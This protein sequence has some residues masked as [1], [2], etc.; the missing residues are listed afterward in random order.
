[1]LNIYEL[2]SFKQLIEEPARLSLIPL[3]IDHI[4]ITHP[5]NTLKSGVHKISL[6]D[7]YMVY[8]VRKLNGAIQNGHK[9]LKARNR[10][11]FREDHFLADIS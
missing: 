4:A 5:Q 1:M 7:H 10:K 11:N 8:C 3:Q 9:T 2:F 6:S